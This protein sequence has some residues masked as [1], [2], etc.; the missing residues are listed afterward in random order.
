MGSITP[1]IHGYLLKTLKDNKSSV[2]ERLCSVFDVQRD[3]VCILY[4][5]VFGNTVGGKRERILSQIQSEN[6]LLSRNVLAISLLIEKLEN[7]LD[8][9]LLLGGERVEHFESR[10]NNLIEGLT[11]NE[12]K[13][14]KIHKD[15][16]ALFKQEIS[17]KLVLLS[18]YLENIVDIANRVEEKANVLIGRG[19]EIYDNTIRL[20][21]KI[22]GVIK[23]VSVMSEEI[24]ESINKR[25]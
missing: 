15:Q 14:L 25:Q 4:M 22:N 5:D 10:L 9:K 1:T 21:Q 18:D 13:V 24:I 6:K 2:N 17:L 8:N 3:R 19:N 23:N 20:E 12:I 7:K 16:L 11:S